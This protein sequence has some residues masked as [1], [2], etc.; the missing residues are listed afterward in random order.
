ML[1]QSFA[2]GSVYSIISPSFIAFYK[3]RSLQQTPHIEI[4][5]SEMV[6]DKESIVM[7]PEVREPISPST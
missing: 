7:I 6:C 5:N 3:I 1:A 4:H 2:R